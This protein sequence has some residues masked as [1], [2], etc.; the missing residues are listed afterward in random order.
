MR[1]RDGCDFS[2]FSQIHEAILPPR[3]DLI[4]R[5]VYPLGHQSHRHGGRL[6]REPERIAQSAGSR[7]PIP[8]L[9]CDTASG[10]IEGITMGLRP[11][12]S[13]EERPRNGK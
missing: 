9:E 12:D 3:P 13:N 6:V 5:R 11:T 10:T 8:G 1:L 7:R 4:A 2:L